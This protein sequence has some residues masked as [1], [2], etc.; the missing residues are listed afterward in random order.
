MVRKATPTLLA[1]SVL[2]AAPATASAATPHLTVISAGI[3]GS[4]LGVIGHAVLGAFSWTIGLAS[5]FVLTTIAALVKL[6][7]PHAW[8]SKG[9]QIM[10][11]I[12]AVPDY[13]G[14]ITAPGGG[15]Q[16]GFQG[17]NALRDLF[18]WLGVAVVP[19]S[20]TYA[21]GRA[22]IGEYEPVGIPVLRVL[23]LAVVIISYPYW[24][25]QAAALTDQITHAILTLPDVAAG[26][27]KL[28]VYAVDGVALGG[29]QL[30]DL[31][32]MGAVG[33]E[34][35]GL[36]FLKVVL[37]LLGA[38]LYA[39]GPLMIGLV[40]TRAGGA[41]ARAW[42]GAVAMLFALGIGWAT[43]FAV[44]ALL[45]NDSGTAGPL[46]AGNSTFGTLVGGLLLA[47]AGL[48]SLWLCLK[49]AKEAGGLMRLQLA[50]LLAL[51]H[52]RG[53]GGSS[54]T[55][56]TR[57]RTTGRSLREYGSRL[58]RAGSAAGGELVG[59]LPGGTALATAGRSA[60]YV[61][62]RGLVGT[63]AAGAGRGAKRAASPTAALVGR[64]RAG[65]VAVRM[66]HAGTASWTSTQRRGAHSATDREQAATP[67]KGHAAHGNDRASNSR[68]SGSA[69]ADGRSSVGRPDAKAQTSA[70]SVRTAAGTPDR[71]RRPAGA[72]GASTSGGATA[73]PVTP[74]TTS[75]RAAAKPQGGAG[76][77]PTAPGTP[78]R[79]G[80]ASRPSGSG[81]P[82]AGATARSSAPRSS[83]GPA[84]G[85]SPPPS[86]ASRR[87]SQQPP[88]SKPPTGPPPARA[89]EPPIRPRRP[90]RK[91]KR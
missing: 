63:A 69:R 56:S 6:L 65:A 46:I 17:I 39:T 51:G 48:A 76:G 62:R 40:P 55:V 26:L 30:I 70:G 29:W 9:L 50:G 67:R 12:V 32:L 64:S 79:S 22:M 19:L 54:A 87:R 23:A 27:Q 28:M 82:G 61:G 77:E 52:S 37:I 90:W 36:I 11:W 89:P 73:R 57:A 58:A 34:L 80:R 44:G 88:T 72:P 5:K 25:S 68:E 66:A 4:I 2:L 86:A 74:P 59:A 20:L 53:G 18:M 60:G 81:T 31:G 3:L 13:A 42:A 10:E 35:L 91:G 83:P 16:Y 78:D 21:T 24:W 43:L 15:Q 85:A 14:K 7:I 71:S 84:P 49:A 75:T 47:V 33:L 41:I 1:V 45:I 8:I 38:L